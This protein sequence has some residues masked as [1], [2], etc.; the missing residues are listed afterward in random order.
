M[1]WGAILSMVGFVISVVT[2]VF[3]HTYVGGWWCISSILSAVLFY[4][5]VVYS[6][7]RGDGREQALID[8]P[9][10]MNFA[11]MQHEPFDE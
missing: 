8:A 3:M 11:C 1:N 2:F 10:R 9:K 6:L 4:V 7:R 5:L